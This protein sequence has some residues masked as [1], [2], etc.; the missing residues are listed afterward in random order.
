MGITISGQEDFFTIAQLSLSREE[1]YLNQ[2]YSHDLFVS[3]A[4]IFTVLSSIFSLGWVATQS[5]QNKLIELLS[6]SEKTSAACALFVLGQQDELLNFSVFNKLVS[7]ENELIRNMA[8]IVIYWGGGCQCKISTNDVCSIDLP[9]LRALSGLE[10]PSKIPTKQSFVN[11]KNILLSGVSGVGKTTVLYELRRLGINSVLDLDEEVEKSTGYN[12]L[13]IFDRFGESVF[14]AI[15]RSVLLD[16]MSRPSADIKVIALGGG[17]VSSQQTIKLAK[18][19]GCLI[20]LSASYPTI[21]KR[22]MA[23]IEAG[24]TNKAAVTLIE[25]LPDT[26][27][28]LLYMYREPFQMAAS[29][30]VINTDNMK[31]CEVANDICNFLGV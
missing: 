29:D 10:K 11:G 8:K 1:D 28:R 25:T 3:P 17:T 15:E 21:V 13:H 31:T 4:D 16:C 20:H 12:L 14:R 27:H 19:E 9:G 26:F 24:K 7:H 22:L 30:Y 5:A 2:L 23:S 18:M 6:S